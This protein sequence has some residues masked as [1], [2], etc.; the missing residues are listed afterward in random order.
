MREGEVEALVRYVARSMN[1]FPYYP[2][3]GSPEARGSHVEAKA[4]S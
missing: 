2:L 3:C 1:L 4:D